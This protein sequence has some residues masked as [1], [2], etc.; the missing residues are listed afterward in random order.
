M[1]GSTTVNI[2]N[3]SKFNY[4]FP[5]IAAS[6]LCGYFHFLVVEKQFSAIVSG[7]NVNRLPQKE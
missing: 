1:A 2:S 7:A 4:N 3:V 5:V 6:H